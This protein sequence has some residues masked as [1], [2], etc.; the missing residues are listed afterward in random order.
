MGIGKSEYIM[1]IGAGSGPTIK[2]ATT[3][4]HFNVYNSEGDILVADVPDPGFFV[5]DF[6][7]TT[8]GKYRLYVDI[9]ADNVSREGLTMIK[10]KRD[11]FSEFVSYF[12]NR[13]ADV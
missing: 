7:Y 4:I 9:S 2:G 13:K 8:L 6:G 10:F 11:D 1:S 12:Y 5:E 3:R